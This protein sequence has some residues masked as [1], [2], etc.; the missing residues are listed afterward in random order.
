MT[1]SADRMRLLRARR[2]GEAPP[3]QQCQACGVTLRNLSRAPWCSHCWRR[4]EAGREWQRE[5][6]ARQ[7]AARRAAEV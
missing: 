6:I 4:T 2:R 1:T 3:L 7:R 5:R